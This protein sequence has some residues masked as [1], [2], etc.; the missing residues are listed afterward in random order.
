MRH[1]TASLE[2]SFPY[3]SHPIAWD[4]QRAFVL[5]HSPWIRLVNHPNRLIHEHAWF[6]VEMDAKYNRR[7]RPPAWMLWKMPVLPYTLVIR[8]DETPSA[9][10]RA[11]GWAIALYVAIRR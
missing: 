5:G 6:M 3:C 10:H 11:I 4:K 2:R 7:Y 8:E 1:T 9:T